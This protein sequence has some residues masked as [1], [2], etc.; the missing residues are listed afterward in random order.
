[1]KNP[2]TT[3]LSYDPSRS[4][5]FPLP[6]LE[7][8]IYLEWIGEGQMDG[9]LLNR[10]QTHIEKVFHCRTRV[11]IRKGSIPLA[12]DPNRKQHSSTVIL[13]WLLEGLP[14]D[15]RKV[16]AVTDRDLF[17]PILTFVF[18]EAQLGGRGAVVSTARLREESG[19]RSGNP[20]LF[21]NRLLKECL[22]ELGHTFG[23]T[24]CA[25]SGCVMERSNT[26]FDVDRKNRA[27]CP[28]C[29][30]LLGD[31]IREEGK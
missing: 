11:R 25:N 17:I 9:S 30:V 10:V 29:A 18:G 13:R 19:G 4:V 16:L 3:D 22:H 20:G 26:V 27:F 7:G 15:A 21:L 8:A 24:H 31:V 1:M 23:L 6:W 5:S 14:R 2:S 28:D 12:F